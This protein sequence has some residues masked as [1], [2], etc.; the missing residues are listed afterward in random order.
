MIKAF[1]YRILPTQGQVD[2]F[3]KSFGS[4]RFIYN[5]GLSLNKQLYEGNNI[6]GFIYKKVTAQSVAEKTTSVI[7]SENISLIKS[8]KHLSGFDLSYL[9]PTL[10]KEKVWLKEIAAKSIIDAL[11]NLDRAYKNF[12]TNVKQGKK[13][14]FPR[15]KS[16]TFSRKSCQFSQGVRVDFEKQLVI[17]PKIGAVNIILHR[18]FNGKI[19]TCTV[20]V[21]SSGKFFISILV[22]NGIELP[23]KKEII[24]ETTV[25]LD[26]GLKTFA[27]L[28]NGIEI[29][30]QT[31][32]KDWER[33][34]A[35]EQRKLQRKY[36]N[37]AEKQSNGYKKQ[38]LVVAKIHE[39]I[40]NIRKDYLGNVSAK[41]IN[42]YNTICIEDLNIKGM[43]VS[44][45]GTVDKPGKM[46]K[47][48]SGLNKSILDTAPAT[49]MNMLTYKAEWQ[50][51]NILKADRFFAS[52]KTCACGKKKTDLTLANRN[53][54]CE[55][56]VINERDLNAANNLKKHCLQKLDLT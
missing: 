45:S 21:E 28:S 2:F 11:G 15:F 9:V 43:T 8:T 4:V 53:W 6:R 29:E 42:D 44:A 20:S 7:Q 35:K 56:G 39:K 49:F 36:V 33:I 54:V 38:K 48:K 46:I 18:P 30:R 41:L 3:L 51:K 47:Q 31:I 17:I 10:K 16:K 13:P 14:G 26:W 40:A 32:T 12:F 37:G 23:V 55:C 34:L 19:K 5:W 27:T 1:K 24:D 52:S 25:G 22:D 50:G